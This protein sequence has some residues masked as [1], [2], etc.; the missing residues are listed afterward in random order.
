MLTIKQ[1]DP[2]VVAEQSKPNVLKE[3]EILGEKPQW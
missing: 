3:G 1:R 2:A